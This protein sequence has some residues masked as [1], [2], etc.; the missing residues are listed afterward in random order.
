MSGMHLSP[1]RVPSWETKLFVRE[2]IITI[3]RMGIIMT[4]IMDTAAIM[5]MSHRR[6][7]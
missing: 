4:T 5:G 1:V 7:L 3:M 2:G 6:V